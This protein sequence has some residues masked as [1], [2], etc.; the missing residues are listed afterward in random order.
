MI[1]IIL[2][3]SKSY[4]NSFLIIPNKMKTTTNAVIIHF[5]RTFFV[6]FP[7]GPI[8]GD[9][10]AIYGFISSFSLS[11]SRAPAVITPSSPASRISNV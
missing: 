7:L 10:W 4:C 8:D 3:Q 9:E 2:K 6:Q 11:L 1:N 5:E